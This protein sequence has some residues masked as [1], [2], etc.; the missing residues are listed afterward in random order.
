MVSQTGSRSTVTQKLGGELREFAFIAAYLYVCFGALILYKTAIL[1]GEGISYTPYG[2]AVVKALL[3]GKFI[4]VGQALRIGD[5]YK[6]RRVIHVIA[7]KAVLFLLMLLVLSVIEEAIVGLIHGRTITASLGEVAGDSLPQILATCFIMLL[8]LIP[9]LSYRELG[10]VLGE[11]RLQQLLFE[12]REGPI[13]H[14]HDG[15]Q[16]G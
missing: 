15:R 14:S 2:I 16:Q 10:E 1:H 5:R 6:S 12:S 9:Y 11:G 13:S 4:L 3:L 7:L 8:I